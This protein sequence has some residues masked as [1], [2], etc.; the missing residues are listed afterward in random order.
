MNR[1]T[2]G[3][4]AHVLTQ[5][6]KAQK[7]ISVFG[8][9]LLGTGIAINVLQ[10]T[11]ALL[12]IG[13]RHLFRLANVHFE[14]TFISCLVLVTW[15]LDPSKLIVQGDTNGLFERYN[16]KG[17][18]RKQTDGNGVGSA[19]SDESVALHM[20]INSL[21]PGDIKIVLK[22]DLQRLPIFGWG[23]RFFEFL[24]MKRKMAEDKK[25][26][27]LV[28]TR[29]MNDKVPCHLLLFPEGTVLTNDTRQ[30][31]DAFAKKADLSYAYKYVLVPR[32]SG[33]YHTLGLMGAG[34]PDG[35][36][37]IWDVTMA[38]PHG[39]DKYAFDEF[40]AFKTFLTGDAPHSIFLH[41]NKIPVSEIPCLPVKGT[42]GD[43][44]PLEFNNWMYG[45]WQKKDDLM[46]NFYKTGSFTQEE[47]KRV[48]SI[49]PYLTDA[50]RILVVLVLGYGTLYFVASVGWSYAVK[51]LV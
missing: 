11:L 1:E 18:A 10:V 50:L 40:S 31:S 17:S 30:K 43:S 23:M 49:R 19:N 22:E 26:M 41:V 25:G 39:I 45:Q 9:I 16:F 7:K 2:N 3:Q 46:A 51:L 14:A 34:Q 33:F 5:A 4:V 29:A 48:V 27:D 24:F 8:I 21:A 47:P 38:Y 20:L 42:L 6:L 12:L 13:N 44:V 35:V 37:E 15:I 36:T 32:V 28:L